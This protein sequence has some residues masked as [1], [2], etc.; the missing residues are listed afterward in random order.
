[1]QGPSVVAI[2]HEVIHDTRLIYTDGRPHIRLSIRGYM[3]DSRGRWDGDTL[4][5]ETTNLTDRTSVGTNGTGPRHGMDMRLTERFTR[6]AADL[7][8]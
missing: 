3:G 5:V 6:T 4:V 7:I 2:T 8:T 1:V